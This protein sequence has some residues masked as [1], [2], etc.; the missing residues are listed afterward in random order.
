[1]QRQ[2]VLA[3]SSRYR[4]G[5]LERL[6]LPFV[7]EVPAVDEAPLPGEGHRA[8]AERLALLKA[9]VAAQR[10]PGSI[11]IGADQVA[12]LDG[13]AIGK[14]ATPS[15]ARQQLLMMRGRTVHFHSG[16]AV[17]DSQSNRS[18]VACVSTDVTFRPLSE[19]TIDTYLRI[20]Q[21]YDCAGSAKIEALG[22]CLVQSVSSDD[23][24]ALI[25]LPLI[26]LTSMLATLGVALPAQSVG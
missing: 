23:P 1:M 26:A 18:L 11:V 25:G 10:R 12:E 7:T 14:P 16:I 24:T 19:Q 8:T 2:I 5:L 17:F 4:Q 3:S 21:P 6:R 20:D 13:I 9:T 22:I 15:A